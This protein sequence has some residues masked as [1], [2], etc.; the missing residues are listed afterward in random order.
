MLLKRFYT[1][2]ESQDFL[3]PME[4]GG[5]WPSLH[6]CSGSPHPTSTASSTWFAKRPEGCANNIFKRGEGGVEAARAR[7]EFG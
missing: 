3:D 1:T 4:Q 5:A 2:K 6:L 7:P